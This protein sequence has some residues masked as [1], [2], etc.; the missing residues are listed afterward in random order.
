MMITTRNTTL[1]QRPEA[2]DIISVNKSI[3]V[4]VLTMV[5][6]SMDIAR[7]IKSVVDIKFISTDNR[8]F[9][10]ILCYKGHY[11]RPLKITTFV[12]TSPLRST[13]PITGVLPPAPCPVLP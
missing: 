11:S 12:S 6:R 3:S 9:S 1:N 13:M 10:D 8:P 4:L 7:M 5:Y 2:L